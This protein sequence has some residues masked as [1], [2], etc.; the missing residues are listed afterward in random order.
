MT[1]IIDSAGY[2]ISDGITTQ[3]NRIEN[4]GPNDASTP[5]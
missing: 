3:T 4:I 5:P 2:A 1:Q